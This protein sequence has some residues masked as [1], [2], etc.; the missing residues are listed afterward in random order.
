LHR[1]DGR[2]AGGGP[3]GLR[4]RAD[5][6]RADLDALDAFDEAHVEATAVKADGSG[7]DQAQ[8]ARRYAAAFAAL[9]IPVD[10]LDEA[11][12]AA[13]V[14]R[15]AVRVQLVEALDDW[16]GWTPD[17]EKVRR[18]TRVAEAAD[19][20]P[21]GLRSRVRR[22]LRDGDPDGLRRAAAEAA[23]AEAPPGLLLRLLAKALGEHRQWVEAVELLEAARRRRPQDFWLNHDLGVAYQRTKP[24]RPDEAVRYLSVAAALRP[25]SAGV[26][27]NLGNALLALKRPAEAAEE[28]RKALDLKPDYAQT[29]NGLGSALRAL[30]RP[31]EAAEEF[32]KALDLKPNYANAHSNLGAA[33]LDLKR[34]GEAEDEYRKV[35]DLMPDLAE[36]HSNLGGALLD[37]KRPAEAAEEFRK[38][39]DL[40][41]D[42]AEAHNGLGSALRALQ[43]PAEAAEECHKALEL[44]PDLAQAHFNL[45]AA[46]LALKRPAEAVEEFRKGLDLKPDDFEPHHSLGAALRDLK[47]PAE[48][49]EE[50]RKAIDLKPD[51]APAHNNLGVVLRALKRPAEAAEEFRKAID[52]K[53]DDFEPHHNLGNALLALKRPAEAAEEFR[54][55]IDLKPDFAEAHCN[56]GAALR[57]LGRFAESLREYRRGHELGVQRRDWPYPSD[58]WV[59]QAETL[60]QLDAALPAVLQGA[61]QPAGPAETAAMARLCQGFKGRYAAAARLYAD[62]FAAAP[63]L[64]DDLTAGY[65]YDA[66]CCAALAAAARGEDAGALGEEERDRLRR[67]ALAWLRADLAGL[68]KLLDGGDASAREAARTALA[69]WRDDADLA[70]VR[71]A[72]ALD[73]LPAAERAEW[74]KLWADVDDLLKRAAPGQ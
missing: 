41:P 35:I 50:Y 6:L 26:W 12:A 40:K 23:A 42:Y 43:R 32:R 22:A 57:D 31:A 44:K 9:G 8:G 38:A 5:E 29:H 36:A 17:V 46:L 68:S 24:P 66:A 1:A 49:A 39:I 70:G 3:D 62:A 53:P 61:A 2:L 60:A 56:L 27:L 47:R 55:A 19:P 33:L 72:D 58:Q 14:G 48:A 28:F 45:G 69:H 63:R 7:Y 10:D 64:A 52:L 13:R 59:R 16:A 18:L 11:E 34:P 67:Q 25:R 74:R 20:E 30:Q 15:C 73:K 54:K 65:R 37:L 21:E 4:A 71:D 51:Y